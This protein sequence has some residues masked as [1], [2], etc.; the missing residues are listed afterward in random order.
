MKYIKSSGGYYYKEYAN[1]KRSRISL[2][3]Y[4]KKKNQFNKQ[5]QDAGTLNIDKKKSQEAGTPAAEIIPQVTNNAN[6]PIIYLGDLFDSSCKGE[7]CKNETVLDRFSFNIRNIKYIKGNIKN[8]HIFLGNR[9]INKLKLLELLK[10]YNE[11]AWKNIIFKSNNIYG[12]GNF[13]LNATVN[14]INYIEQKEESLSPL[15]DESNQSNIN[16][17]ISGEDKTTE[18][19]NTA[20]TYATVNKNELNQRWKYS[21]KK[22]WDKGNFLPYWN[23]NKKKILDN[24]F[25]ETDKNT[26][27]NLKKNITHDVVMQHLK[28]TMEDKRKEEE[29]LREQLKTENENEKLKTNINN[30]NLTKQNIQE[31]RMLKEKYND[32]IQYYHWYGDFEVKTCNDMFD[33]IFGADPKLGTMSADLLKDSIFN[34]IIKMY[35]I[36][37]FSDIN[38]DNNFKSALALVVFKLLMTTSKKIEN[39]ISTTN[40]S[41]EENIKKFVKDYSFADL[42]LHDNVHFCKAIEIDNRVLC[43]SHSGIGKEILTL[44]DFENIGKIY[45]NN[46]KNSNNITLR[47]ITDHKYPDKNIITGTTSTVKSVNE[48]NHNLKKKLKNLLEDTMNQK[49]INQNIYRF[50]YISASFDNKSPIVAKNYNE[51]IRS[52]DKQ[53]TVNGKNII[54]FT[55]HQPVGMAP[56]FNVSRNTRNT[57]TGNFNIV[58]SIDRY[59]NVDNLHNFETQY[60][61]YSSIISLDKGENI[62]LKTN[63]T[64][65][66]N[67]DIYNYNG[68][69][70][71]NKYSF[72]E[73]NK[74]ININNNFDLVT[75]TFKYKKNN[76]CNILD[77]SSKYNNIIGVDNKL[78]LYETKTAGPPKFEKLLNINENFSCNNSSSSQ[79][80]GGTF[81]ISNYNS[82]DQNFI[83]LIKKNKLFLLS[84][85]EGLNM[86]SYIDDLITFDNAPEEEEEEE[87]EER[88]VT[89]AEAT[90]EADE[91]T[92]AATEEKE[93]LKNETATK[94]EAAAKTEAKKKINELKEK[95]K[96]QEEIKR[97]KHNILA[98]TIAK[99]LAF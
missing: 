62:N 96:K 24:L 29:K 94:A 30:P 17:S 20:I 3:E 22:E 15:Q 48:L 86:E 9:D 27:N 88:S 97:N 43:F 37:N 26:Y 95:T 77:L 38:I 72:N 63:I 56:V 49:E 57:N 36:T 23:I 34:E 50:L 6:K 46:A 18:S 91:V 80:G 69:D 75:I 4:N 5:Q 87:E 64:F 54:Q 74:K 42:L 19:L 8:I 21:T 11:D 68:I 44:E 25:K 41:T 93:R 79:N 14:L 78:K 12:N 10:L 70:E 55:G 92:T 89:E 58:F 99:L 71:N 67:A 65:K 98:R 60:E 85:L 61:N 53:I 73:D 59:N 82:L 40:S 2:E 51:L 81:K 7:K 32:N 13:L 31:A 35:D 84:D 28:K 39:I 90:A 1:G 83:N 33:R 66:K 52:H 47:E 16:E 45:T 76:Q